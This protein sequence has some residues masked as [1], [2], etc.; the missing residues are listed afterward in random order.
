M[1]MHLWQHNQVGWLWQW[2]QV[3]NAQTKERHQNAKK[4]WKNADSGKPDIGLS[5]AS[6]LPLVLPH[7]A[8][9][10]TSHCAPSLLTHIVHRHSRHHTMVDLVPDGDRTALRWLFYCGIRGITE[11]RGMVGWWFNQCRTT[12]GFGLVDELLLLV[13]DVNPLEAERRRLAQ[14]AA[15]QRREQERIIKSRIEE[16]RRKHREE[17]QALLSKTFAKPEEIAVNRAEDAT[18]IHWNITESPQQKAVGQVRI[19]ASTTKLAHCR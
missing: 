5:H 18:S 17:R 7:I 15:E 12:F 10:C 11:A 14:E 1:S 13:Y 3:R 6:I 2:R 19:Q 4:R 8:C 16:E 9:H